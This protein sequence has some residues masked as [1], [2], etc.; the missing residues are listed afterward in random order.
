MAFD[1][2]LVTGDSGLEAMASVALEPENLEVKSF[3]SPG[4]ALSYLDSGAPNPP[5]VVLDL[6]MS[7]LDAADFLEAA[8]RNGLTSPVLLLSHDGAAAVAEELAA[9]AALTKP[10]EPEAFVNAVQHILTLE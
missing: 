6:D 7:E 4:E 2:L 8:R 5:A 9:A 1:V 3:A 10:I